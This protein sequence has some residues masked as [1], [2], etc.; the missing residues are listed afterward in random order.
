MADFYTVPVSW[1]DG[2]QAQGRALGNN[3]AWLCKCNEILIGT[4][5]YVPPHCPICNR[6]YKIAKGE[7]PQYIA[8]IQET[9]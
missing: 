5:M 3:V 4:S 9:T 7:K 1:T 8:T 6:K 2:S